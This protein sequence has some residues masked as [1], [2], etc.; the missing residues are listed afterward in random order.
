MG[1]CVRQRLEHF[2]AGLCVSFVFLCVLFFPPLRE[3]LLRPASRIHQNLMIMIIWL[4]N[5]LEEKRTDVMLAKHACVECEG[6]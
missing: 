3:L 5:E 2:Q 4:V 6:N 1:G